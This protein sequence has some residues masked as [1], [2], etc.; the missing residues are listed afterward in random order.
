MQKQVRMKIETICLLLETHL[1]GMKRFDEFL[2][3][4]ADKGSWDPGVACF[5]FTFGA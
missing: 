3:F 4:V 2:F 1:F 5:V